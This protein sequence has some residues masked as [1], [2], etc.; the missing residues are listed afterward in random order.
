MQQVIGIQAFCANLLLALEAKQDEVCGMVRA[1]VF[2]HNL[3][4][5]YRRIFSHLS[6]FEFADGILNLN[7]F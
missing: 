6:L 7:I 1:F 3:L 2:S 4:D 5:F